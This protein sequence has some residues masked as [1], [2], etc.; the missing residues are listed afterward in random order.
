MRQIIVCKKIK[1]NTE[2]DTEFL[3]LRNMITKGSLNDVWIIKY[4]FMG[5][6]C[7][8]KIEA[9]EMGANGVYDASTWFYA[10]PLFKYYNSYQLVEMSDDDYI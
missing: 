5:K 9:Y 6:H 7:L 4:Y 2:S 10:N 8:E 3:T 1:G